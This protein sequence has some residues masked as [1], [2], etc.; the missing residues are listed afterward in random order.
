[1]SSK[2]WDAAGH[3][4]FLAQAYTVKFLCVR[5]FQNR[6]ADSVYSLLKI[7]IDRFG[8]RDAF[9]ITNNSIICTTTG[10][11][12][13]FY[14]L[15][16]NTSE[17]KSIEGVDILW[18]EE[19]HL[20]T[21]AQWDILEPTIRADGSECWII[22]NPGIVSDFSWRHFVIKAEH[23]SVVMKINYDNNPFLSKT[24][25]D[26]IDKARAADEEKYQHIYGGEPLANDE[27]SIIKRS[28]IMASI[29]AHHILNMPAI[30][31]KRIGYDVADSGADDNAAA[32]AQGHVLLDLDL[33]HGGEDELMRS[34]K[35][36]YG[37]ARKHDAI[38]TYDPIG[39]GAGC[40]SKFREINES[41]GSRLVKYDKFTAS[42]KVV[43]PD[44]FYEPGVRNKD[45]FANAKAQAWQS[46]GDR[47]CNTYNAIHHGEVFDESDLISIDVDLP[48]LVQL[49]DELSVVKKDYDTVGRLLVESKKDLKKRDIPSPNL[50][51]AVVMAYCPKMPM[52]NI[53]TTNLPR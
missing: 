40:G 7:Q 43:R 52:M 39:V 35:R 9:K 32:Y 11:E 48:H 45:M 26:V 21:E 47:F 30:G 14:G 20:L 38:I 16:R 53:N 46:L 50:A 12:F 23:D 42:G 10:S 44:A 36:V 2:S 33:W 34:C 37:M 8:L 19:S 18:S 31:S 27:D 13:M 28:W 29:D 15:A 25:R 1:M 22:F 41:S 49:I 3:A 6:I 24:A 4:I 5:Q 51:D 17:I